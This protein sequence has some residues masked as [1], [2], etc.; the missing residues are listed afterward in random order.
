M[1]L[2]LHC[3]LVDIF[4]H[5]TNLGAAGHHFRH[6]FRHNCGGKKGRFINLKVETNLES[7]GRGSSPQR[8]VNPLFCVFA[9]T[10]SGDWA[11]RCD[12]HARRGS[13]CDNCANYS[14]AVTSIRQVN[15]VLFLK[16]VRCCI[17]HLKVELSTN[18]WY[19]AK[20]SIFGGFQLP[21]LDPTASM[22][23]NATSTLVINVN[24]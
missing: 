20:W 14:A 3:P 12:P 18:G 17:T 19:V 1:F 2:S 7:R 6:H 5:N 4:S 13:L 21:G 11:R 23:I 8:R 15:S 16:A 10:P 9:Q 24:N 22:M